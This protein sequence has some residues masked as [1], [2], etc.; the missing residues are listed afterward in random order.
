MSKEWFKD[1]LVQRIFPVWSYRVITRYPIGYPPECVHQYK[2][3]FVDS[4]VNTVEPIWGGPNNII[5]VESL[6]G[7]HDGGCE[8]ASKMATDSLFKEIAVIIEYLQR[9]EAFLQGSWWDTRTTRRDI[10]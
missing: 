6:H 4:N 9:K 1:E 7:I 8:D 10:V 3:E 2:L 5:L